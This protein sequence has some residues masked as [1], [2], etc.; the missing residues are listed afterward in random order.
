MNCGVRFVRS[1]GLARGYGF[2]Q[3]TAAAA[4]AEQRI[5]VSDSLDAIA[6]HIRLLI[7]L[8]RRVEGY[9]TNR[10]TLRASEGAGH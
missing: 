10:E 9:D 1:K 8:I 6:A 4:A 3:I 7:D 2:P 5:K